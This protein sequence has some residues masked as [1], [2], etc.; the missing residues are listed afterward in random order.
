[1][2]SLKLCVNEK[3]E[4]LGYGFVSYGTL[5]G[6]SKAKFE[7]HTSP[8]RKDYF[9]TVN[10]FEPKELRAAKKL[11]KADKEELENYR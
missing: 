6:A 7:A 11:E 8:F 3:R 9:L 1:V 5:D 4:L 10:E 2:K